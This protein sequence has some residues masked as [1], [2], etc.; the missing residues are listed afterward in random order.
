MSRKNTLIDFINKSNVKHN[1]Y[2]IY[3]KVSYVNNKIPVI[4]ICPK[5]GE[6]IIRPDSHLHGQGCKKCGIDKRSILSVISIDVTL[7]RLYNIHK[8]SFIYCVDGNNIK[9]EDSITAK[10]SICN[11]IFSRKLDTFLIKSVGCPSCNG[12]I[13]HNT[14]TFKI[15]AI[16]IHKMLYDYKLVNYI[17]TYIPVKIICNMCNHIFDQRP[18]DHFDGHGCP[19]CIRRISKPELLFLEYCKIPND[20]NHRQ[21]NILRKKV[22]GYDPT[23]NTI[24]EFLGDYWHGNPSK[25]PNNNIHPVVKITYRE[26]YNRTVNRMSYLYKNGYNIKYVWETEWNMFTLNKLNKIPIKEYIPNIYI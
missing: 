14:D 24:Y 13:D 25:Y 1:N 26:L 15:K 11:F 17:D 3:E 7:K 18:N 8:H 21:V 19:Y 16:S 5:H 22:D 20:V 10:C 12:C 23:T 6:F 4:I 9:R 2:F